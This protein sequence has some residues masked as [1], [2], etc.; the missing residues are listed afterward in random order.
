MA[1]KGFCLLLEAVGL[2]RT[3][4]LGQGSW[5]FGPHVLQQAAALASVSTSQHTAGD[6]YGFN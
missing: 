6:Y 5:M 2:A 3:T 1:F 4:Y